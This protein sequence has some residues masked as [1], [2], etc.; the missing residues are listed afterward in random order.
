MEPKEMSDNEAKE[1]LQELKEKHD[2]SILEEDI[3]DNKIEF[4][5]KEDTYRVRLFNRQD[6]EEI[7]FLTIKKY[8]QLLQD[9]DILKE[10]QLYKVYKDK[11]I[12]IDIVDL[13]I[14]RLQNEISELYLKLGEE[15]S[16]KTVEE[17]CKAY[18]DKIE[19]LR[20]DMNLLIIK[21]ARL[22]NHSLENLLESYT[23]RT[24]LFFTLEKKVNDN[25][26]RTFKSLQE[27]ETTE[28]EL[29]ICMAE[30]YHLKLNFK[31]Q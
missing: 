7:Y 27:F 1:M 18:H 6:K 8:N 9:P 28:E 10:E 24:S 12:D 26:I 2:L 17:V 22:L 19:A 15:E 31:T 3:K 21:R 11:G 5:Y 25:W 29:L 16:K 14:R 13:Q 20:D 23:A 4:F 30:I